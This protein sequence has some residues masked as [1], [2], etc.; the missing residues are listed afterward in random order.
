MIPNLET[1]SGGEDHARYGALTAGD[2]DAAQHGDAGEQS[3]GCVD[4]NRTNQ[5]GT[6]LNI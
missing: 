6:R 2:A 1:M 4:P 5:I 3:R